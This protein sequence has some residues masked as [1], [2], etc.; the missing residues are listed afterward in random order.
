MSY[1]LRQSTASQEV[2]LGCFVLATD[3]D[4]DAGSLTIANTDIKLLK[5]GGST[6]ISKNSGG[7]TYISNGIYY[8]TLDA[9]D[10]NTL[11]GLVIFVHVA[12][13]LPVKLDCVVYRADVFDGLFADGWIPV[14][15]M[16]PDWSISSTTLT[17]QPPSTTAN[18]LI[19]A[20]TGTP[21]ANPITTVE[22][23]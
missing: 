2:P 23:S 22:S 16:A 1:P 7:A 14:N 5:H 15:P 8:C 18:Q 9:T 6:A 11:G 3:G 17:V 13:A 20:L 10:T 19:K 12:T 4:T 21:G